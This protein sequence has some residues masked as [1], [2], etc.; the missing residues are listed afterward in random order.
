MWIPDNDLE[1]QMKVIVCSHCSL[2]G[3]RGRDV[4]VS[5]IKENFYWRE[6]DKDVAEFVKS[7]IHCIITR[8][9]EI[10]PRPLGTA[11]HGTKANEVVHIDYLYIARS[12]RLHPIRVLDLL[13][14]GHFASGSY[15][16]CPFQAK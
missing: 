10:V 2:M 9:G 11:L 7:C 6:M 4:T 3:H 15:E 12:D 1:L 5:T 16:I 8:S 14:L 13:A